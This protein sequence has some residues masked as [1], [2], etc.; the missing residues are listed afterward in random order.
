MTDCVQFRDLFEAYA[1]GAL[2]AEERS[3]LESHLAGGCA[4]CAKS[5]GEARWVVSQLAY[6][7]P[8]SAPS[9]MLKGRLMQTVRA[10][11]GTRAKQPETFF[12]SR[13]IPFWMWAGVAALLIVTLYS[14]WDARR[15]H[16]ELIAAS[17]EVAAQSQSRAEAERN[18]S[19][20]RESLA[21]AKMEAAILMD[22]AST[23]VMLAAQNT[24]APAMEAMWHA[25][26]GIV[27]A[28]QKIPMP[29][30]DRVLQLWLIP[31]AP[32]A[33]PIPSMTVRPDRDGKFILLVSQPPDVAGNTKALAITEEPSGG[34]AAPTTPPSWVGSIT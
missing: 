11:A 29:R 27:L 22:P 12:S 18:L 8:E 25:K 19:S 21:V 26:W 24:K 34:S 23:K 32:G 16:Q 14:V 5:L 6:I 13:A 30:G 1:L 31:K 7:A 20:A 17:Q 33:K 4:D 9:D 28:G 10:E 2:D 15:A 3:A